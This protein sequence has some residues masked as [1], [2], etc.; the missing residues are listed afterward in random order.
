MTERNAV[1]EAPLSSKQVVRKV[2]QLT[3]LTR[4]AVGN[5]DYQQDAVFVTPSKI[6]ASNKKTRVLAM[7]CD[8]MGGMADGGKASRTA[9]QMIVQ[10]F[11]RVEKEPE[12]NIPLFFRQGIRAADRAI[13]EFP[14][15]NG[16][17][18]GTTMVACIGEGY[19]WQHMLQ[20]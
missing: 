1:A 4:S 13:Y 15:E 10:G 14:K 3:T 12:L 20:V 11:Q 8:G 9:I 17:G 2:S 18:S 19:M 6:L 5:R 16:R 7:V